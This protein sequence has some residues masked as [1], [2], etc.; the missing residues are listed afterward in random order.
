M[1]LCQITLTTCSV[2]C[3]VGFPPVADLAQ[4][5]LS[6]R[7]RHP[8]STASV[9][10]QT[11]VS[12]DIRSCTPPDTSQLPHQSQQPRKKKQGETIREC[13]KLRETKAVSS[14]QVNAACSSIRQSAP[15][16][17]VVMH[18]I[19]QPRSQAVSTSEPC[20][21]SC[22]PSSLQ[23]DSHLS[24]ESSAHCV[25]AQEPQSL[26]ASV[27]STTQC[28]P[29]NDNID[30]SHSITI[31]GR[32]TTSDLPVSESNLHPAAIS[33]VGVDTSSQPNT[34]VTPTVSLRNTESVCK[35]VSSAAVSSSHALLWLPSS[36]Q[37][38]PA[39]V[40]TTADPAHRVTER[41]TS[42]TV[43]VD[44]DIGS[45]VLGSGLVCGTFVY[46]GGR[47][48]LG[49]QRQN[50]SA[51]PVWPLLPE[52][53]PC[54]APV[55]FLA[56]PRPVVAPSTNIYAVTV[57]NETLLSGLRVV[58]DGVSNVVSE[59][60][61]N[62]SATESGCA[63]VAVKSSN[64]AIDGTASHDVAVTSSI[65]TS[66]DSGRSNTQPSSTDA[67]QTEDSATVA[68]GD[69]DGE[70]R[71]GKV[72]GST[73]TATSSTVDSDRESTRT[74]QP[75]ELADGSSETVSRSVAVSV[76]S[77]L[78]SASSSVVQE[79]P[80]IITSRCTG[81]PVTSSDVV[82]GSQFVVPTGAVASQFSIA[83]LGPANILA[84]SSSSLVSSA[85]PTGDCSS[86]SKAA[87]RECTAAVAKQP[88]QQGLKRKLV[89][90]STDECSSKTK[91]GRTDSEKRISKYICPPPDSAS[92]K[93]SEIIHVMD[94]LCDKSLGQYLYP[95]HGHA[96][97]CNASSHHLATDLHPSNSEDHVTMVN[98]L[99][100]TAAHSY[101]S[102]EKYSAALNTSS[103]SSA[104]QSS[105]LN[106]EHMTP[107]TQFSTCLNAEDMC[108]NQ[109]EIS[110]VHLHENSSRVDNDSVPSSHD[111]GFV[112]ANFLST[113]AT[114]TMLISSSSHQSSLLDSTQTS[115]TVQTEKNNSSLLIDH[116]QTQNHNFVPVSKI[117]NSSITCDSNILPDD[118]S[119][120]DND[121]AMIFSD[122]D[123]NSTISLPSRKSVDNSYWSIGFP[124]CSRLRDRTK[125]G[126]G[127]EP[128]HASAEDLYH[129][130][131]PVFREQNCMPETDYVISDHLDL[132]SRVC[133]N[134]SSLTCKTTSVCHTS[135]S[136][137]TANSFRNNTSSTLCQISVGIPHSYSFLSQHNEALP[138]HA[139]SHNKL[140]E[141]STTQVS[142]VICSTVQSSARGI[143]SLAH[144]A[145]Q[146]TFKSFIPDP[147]SSTEVVQS[148]TVL[149][150]P[151][152]GT[153]RKSSVSSNTLSGEH[154]QSLNIGH[155]CRLPSSAIGD[156]HWRMHEP[157]SFAPLYNSWSDNLYSTVQ[158]LA[159]PRP[160][161]DQTVNSQPG[162]CNMQPVF[163]H[164][165]LHSVSE[166]DCEK[167]RVRW[168]EDDGFCPFASNKN[169]P[170]SKKHVHLNCQYSS[171]Q[172]APDSSSSQPLWTYPECGIT[173]Q[174]YLSTS[175]G[176]LPTSNSDTAP[177]MI[178]LSLSAPATS[179][180]PASTCRLPPF[181]FATVPPVP[182]FL[183]L[184][185]ASTTASINTVTGS[186]SEVCTWPV[187]LPAATTS[188]S[189]PYGW[190]PIFPQH[191]S[192]QSRHMMSMS[193]STVASLTTVSSTHRQETRPD[194]TYTVPSFVHTDKESQKQPSSLNTHLPSYTLWHG[195]EYNPIEM[196]N[197]PPVSVANS[198]VQLLHI[199]G[200]GLYSSNEAG[201]I[202]NTLT[203][204]PLHHHPLY[205]SQQAGL[206]GTVEK[207]VAFET[208]FSLTR[209][210]LTSQVLNFS[211]PFE[212]ITPAARAVSSQMYCDPT[213][214]VGNMPVHIRTTE[215]DTCRSQNVSQSQSVARQA[216]S[217]RPPK[218]R[219]QLKHNATSLCVGYP[220][221]QSGA[222]S[223]AAAGDVPT[224]LP[225]GPFV[226]STLNQKSHSSEYQVGAS[227]GSVFGSCSLRHGLAGEIPK[228]LSMTADPQASVSL[229]NQRHNF[230][231]GAFISD[232]PSNSLQAVTAPAAI[233]RLDFP[234]PP[235][236]VLRQPVGASSEQCQ[237]HME[238]N[239]SSSSSSDFTSHNFGLH[240]MSINSLLGDNPYPAFTHRYEVYS[241][242]VNHST[243]ML[244]TY[245]V[246]TL[247]FSIRS[248]TSAVNYERAQN[249]K[250]RH[251]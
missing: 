18:G 184:S 237:L 109:S 123:D 54:Q 135:L 30:N 79:P 164:P 201:F 176:W 4:L 98:V 228:S 86:G 5:V 8:A 1:A 43:V 88:H 41:I 31:P 124:V 157:S 57:P 11:T 121:F 162:T 55:Y 34:V 126:P 94:R 69:S 10:C 70:R 56:G 153:A 151:C 208:P 172:K 161:V 102:S 251:T 139:N 16:D 110:H 81:S 215:E 42:G 170:A 38:F 22:V 209:L 84:S 52:V 143:F 142:N 67:H 195:A 27:T 113:T 180:M 165:K 132:G 224:Y 130:F 246:P 232:L 47:L 117:C 226:G 12:G 222:V 49:Q 189:A 39:V 206:Y 230:D 150:S 44:M 240:N 212:T 177:A 239:Q 40:A 20:S 198:D 71:N 137:Q 77:A 73:S 107:V 158:P 75:C 92:D 116:V 155:Q 111:K 14:S 233:R 204:P 125:D 145:I 90:Q 199:H 65:R 33:Q 173:P 247:N 140:Q 35:V 236:H 50:N 243:S 105:N 129:S 99:P 220:P 96:S 210:P 89:S 181:S 122:T 187:T 221:N 249:T 61:V 235:V 131:V 248:Q 234:T 128:L 156:V 141:T 91:I 186:G 2:F 144:H 133:F 202:S 28:Q 64:S 103:M 25:A 118:L 106:H 59:V 37:Q 112:L 245:D 51:F 74:A 197:L 115:K 229:P 17:S 13:L 24:A 100:A 227:F 242:T 216:N 148:T 120:T 160:F 80:Q 146:P 136:T 76:P 190:S 97:Y 119:L 200:R 60:P 101:N 15:T 203:S 219:K 85:L 9:Y 171:H 95:I 175:R 36:T 29:P 83:M 62:V 93:D 58:C 7:P 21:E 211:T 250:V 23:L 241:D 167:T 182:D 185:L 72:N 46:H 159:R 134:V 225:A 194:V 68:A 166:A 218:Y 214:N 217:K 174:S 147:I 114:P 26:L 3:V 154:R 169:K 32:I 188:T 213:F 168:S 108:V 104:I 82:T 53:S 19:C 163:N 48:L 178:D 238:C 193:S 191:T 179:S 87:S 192:H 66:D 231:I 127:I 244:P 223:Q 138:V 149:W 205:S 78:V 6:W 45:S 183:S 207:Q 63:T 196:C 152:N